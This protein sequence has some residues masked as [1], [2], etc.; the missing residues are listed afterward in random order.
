[1]QALYSIGKTFSEHPIPV[2]VLY[3]I[4][5]V[6]VP[7]GLYFCRAYYRSNP[8]QGQMHGVNHVNSNGKQTINV[9]EN[10][11]SVTQQNQ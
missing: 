8:L 2:W 1:M 7:A 4:L 6:V 10:N 3:G 5:V 11:G 9:N